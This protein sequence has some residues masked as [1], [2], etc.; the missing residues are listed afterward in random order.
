MIHQTYTA[1]NPQ[2][3]PRGS[4]EMGPSAAVARFMQQA[5]TIRTYRGASAALSAFFVPGECWPWTLTLTFELVRDFCTLHLTTMFHH[6][7]FNLSKVIMRTNKPTNKHTPLKTSTLLRHAT[8][9]GNHVSDVVIK[10]CQLVWING[11]S[12]TASR[13]AETFTNRPRYSVC[14]VAVGRI[15][16]VLRCG[17]KIVGRFH[18]FMCVYVHKVSGGGVCWPY[19]HWGAAL[20]SPLNWG[21]PVF[22]L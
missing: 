9:V 15:Y 8:P 17:L 19:G 7:T 16:V 21:L 2:K 5:D 11:S 22:A 20:Q 6:P 14:T 13:K 18:I 4:H 1:R 3:T 12:L 10:V